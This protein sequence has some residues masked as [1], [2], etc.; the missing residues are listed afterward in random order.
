LFYLLDLDPGQPITAD[1]GEFSDWRWFPRSVVAAWPVERTDPEL[2]RFL[3][4][5]DRQRTAAN[6]RQPFLKCVLL[7]RRRSRPAVRAGIAEHGSHAT[8]I[9]LTSRRQVPRL[10]TGLGDHPAGT[11]RR[12]DSAGRA[13]GRP[14]GPEGDL[15][16]CSTC[17]GT[18]SDRWRRG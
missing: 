16:S 12:A 6:L 7:F 10:L 1:S 4:K 14:G 15:G 3:A 8:L 9:E 13:R 11:H 18:T 17:K 2:G 5:L